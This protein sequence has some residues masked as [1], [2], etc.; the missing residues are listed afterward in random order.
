MAANFRILLLLA[1][2]ACV[3]AAA[4]ARAD[5]AED[6]FDATAEDNT[7]DEDAD[8][9]FAGEAKDPSF[10]DARV[11]FPELPLD[12]PLKFPAG[13]K[14][15]TF[16]SFQNKVGGTPADI[17]I[18]AAHLNQ[19]GNS[20]AF[21][22]NFSAIR[23][24]R[25][26]NGGET[27]TV[28]YDFRPDA[29][30]EPMDYNLVIRVFFLNAENTTFVAVA[31]NSTVTIS[32][33]LGTDFKAITSY[34]ILFGLIAGAVYLFAGKKTATVATT[35]KSATSSSPSFVKAAVAK[36]ASSPVSGDEK[37]F[38]T[39]YIS[40]EHLKYREQL[41]KAAANRAGSPKSPANKKK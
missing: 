11:F 39:D 6:D 33:P 14:V 4:F 18:V 34:I 41:I 15:S 22:Q 3:M 20:E 7:A 9:D 38:N 2:L 8:E 17:F 27:A 28:R 35:K 21:V 5:V 16:V 26:V 1:L 13:E 19:I 30:L 29:M 24:P 12:A 31:Y 37:G 40:P 23:S 32:D 25:T 10:I 36:A